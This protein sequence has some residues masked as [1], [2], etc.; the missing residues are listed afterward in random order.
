MWHWSWQAKGKAEKAR[1]VQLLVETP[2]RSKYLFLRNPG[3]K[4]ATQF[5]WNCSGWEA[6]HESDGNLLAGHCPCGAGLHRL[7][8]RG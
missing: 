4:T 3:R 5:S 6:N 7:C 1:A 2:N 8:G